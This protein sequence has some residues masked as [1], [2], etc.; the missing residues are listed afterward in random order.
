MGIPPAISALITIFIVAASKEARPIS[1]GLVQN[2]IFVGGDA[3]SS[4]PDG[5]NVKNKRIDLNEAVTLPV[6]TPDPIRDRTKNTI[7]VVEEPAGIPFAR[8]STLD[9]TGDYWEDLHDFDIFSEESN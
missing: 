3:V 5:D 1:E 6:T 9:L 2:P 8:H 7:L 4:V